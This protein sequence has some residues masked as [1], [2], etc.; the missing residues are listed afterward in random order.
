[1][2]MSV[3]RD[4]EGIFNITPEYVVRL[5]LKVSVLSRERLPYAKDENES[6][7]GVLYLCKGKTFLS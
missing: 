4:A 3:R 2:C 5:I 1:M 6:M 7:Q